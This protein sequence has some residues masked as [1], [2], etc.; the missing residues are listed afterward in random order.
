MTAN[1]SNPGARAS[2]RWL[3][4]GAAAGLL[5]ATLSVIGE[6]P[7]VDDLPEG[8]VARVGDAL[9][10]LEDYER[11]V[12]G[13]ESD[14]RG[15]VDGELRR[16]VLDRMIDEELLV[17]RAVELG[18]VDVDRRVRAN[19]TSSMI[20]SVVDDA[21]DVEPGDDELREFYDEHADFFTSPG[22]LRVRQ[23]FFR[24]R[25]TER[26]SPEERAARAV[27]ALAAGQPFDAVRKE[28][29][30][31]EISPLPDVLLPALKLREYVGPTALRSA[32]VLEVG[33]ISDPIRSGTGVH[34]LQLVDREEPRTPPFEQ[35][36]EQ[37]HGEW[38]RRQGD[39]ALRAYLD[40]L[41]EDVV[42][43]TR[44]V[45]VDAD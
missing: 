29:G 7:S 26:G 15:P 20:Q 22:R 19:L 28:H 38:R 36:E 10:R 17:Q 40:G 14:R 12:A 21:E 33:E 6:R 11:L 45:E 2:Q 3:A 31:D 23:I 4:A 34:I 5:V 1:D 25:T 18:L 30:D 43:I 9:I 41:R 37:V 13:L 16:H 32:L 35:I 39:R 42:V 8:A 24:S 44:K 27:G